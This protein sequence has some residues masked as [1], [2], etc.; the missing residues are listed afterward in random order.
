MLAVKNLLQNYSILYN[1]VPS[2]CQCVDPK[3]WRLVSR[4]RLGSHSNTEASRYQCVCTAHIPL[5]ALRARARIHSSRGRGHGRD[6]VPTWCV[7]NGKSAKTLTTTL[8]GERYS[9]AR[10]ASVTYAKIVQLHTGGRSCKVDNTQIRKVE[11][12]WTLKSKGTNEEQNLKSRSYD[13]FVAPRPPVIVNKVETKQ[14]LPGKIL[15][16]WM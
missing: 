15:Y 5:L 9:T 3:A 6:R 12:D 13:A 8:N 10:A 14:S 11:C 2:S 7:N 4:L 16:T 1:C